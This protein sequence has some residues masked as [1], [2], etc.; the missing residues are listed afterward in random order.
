MKKIIIIIILFTLVNNFNFA[1]W[2]WQ[3]PLPQGNPLNDIAVIDNN[4]AY[5]VGYWGTIIKTTD[6]GFT[7]NEK[8]LL[9]HN[10][11]NSVY[12]LNENIGWA[13][14]DTGSIIKT[15][16]G[17]ENWTIL[18]SGTQQ[19]LN[20][21]YFI[22]ENRGFVLGD[23]N[24]FLVSD[25]GGVNWAPVQHNEASSNFYDIVFINDSIG[26]VSGGMASILKTVDGGD[27]WIRQYEPHNWELTEI[28]FVG[29]LNGWAVHPYPNARILR[30]TDGGMNWDVQL[31]NIDNAYVNDLDFIDSN[32]GFFVG[33]IGGNRGVIYKTT[34]GGTNWYAIRD[35]LSDTFSA[36]DIF[37]NTIWVVGGRE[38]IKSTDL[39]DVWIPQSNRLN[40]FIIGDADFV[41]ENNGWLLEGIVPKLFKT[42]DGGTTWIS[43]NLTE[44]TKSI[45]FVDLQNGWIVGTG[46]LHTTDGGENWVRQPV[47]STQAPLEKVFFTNNQVG[48]AWGMDTLLQT[49]DGGNNWNLKYTFD[50]HATLRSM[51]FLNENIGWLNYNDIILK[52]TDG[53]S[54]WFNQTNPTQ[55]DLGN[56]KFFN[57]TIGWAVG[58]E[59]Y[60]STDGGNSWTEQRGFNHNNLFQIEIINENIIW[61]A[62]AGTLWYTDNGGEDWIQVNCKTASTIVSF[63]FV[64]SNTGWIVGFGGQILKTTNGGVTFIED[65]K[66]NYNQPTEFLLS[67]NYPNPFNSSSIIKYSVPKSSQ[68]SL[69]IFNALGE[70]IAVLVN[71]EKPVGTYELTWNAANMS[72]GVYLYRL[73]A[74]NFTQTRKLILLK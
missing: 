61:A 10:K 6:G 27:N 52:T 45:D 60:K 40:I 74:G 23:W 73:Q 47:N 64:N 15:I 28:D 31:L 7:W 46:I 16:D 36:M 53:G 63:S 71:E 18:N 19:K 17:G 69:K 25:D 9:I 58:S 43:K 12:F 5:A 33:G 30:T 3:N 56:V 70:E 38:I 59:I 48:W 50:Y 8:S 42:I 14:G 55:Y 1:Q 2:F 21:V 39:G 4:I 54:I 35:S 57:D 37:D 44:G 20:E 72:S 32:V 26:W 29:D 34:D 62:G 22:N 24:I 13:V 66:N 41:D 68:V 51:F 11:L 67:Q 49:I 65:E